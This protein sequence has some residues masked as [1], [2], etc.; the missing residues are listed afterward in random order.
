MPFLSLNLKIRR[1]SAA[2]TQNDPQES[3]PARCSATQEILAKVAQLHLNMKEDPDFQ[4]GV[5]DEI[6]KDRETRMSNASLRLHELRTQM[7]KRKAGGTRSLEV[8]FKP[9]AENVNRLERETTKSQQI[10]EERK[11]KNFLQFS[12]GIIRYHDTYHDAGGYGEVRMVWF[13]PNETGSDRPQYL[14]MKT[15]KPRDLDIIN[16]ERRFT[17]EADIWKL[18]NHENINPLFDV[19]KAQLSDNL[20]P[21]PAI[22]IL[23]PWAD[24]S[25]NGMG[26]ATA[27][28]QDSVNRDQT[29]TILSGILNGLQYMH[30]Q[31]DAVYHGDLKGNNVLLFGTP[32]NPV[33]KLTD[34]GL[35]K[36]CSP[37]PVQATK[38]GGNPLWTAPEIVRQKHQDV[39]NDG[40]PLPELSLTAEADLWGFGMTAFELITRSKVPM[41]DRGSD[42]DL[43]RLYIYGSNE[44]IDEE[45]ADYLDCLPTRLRP[46]L[47]FCLSADPSQRPTITAF[48]EEWDQALRGPNGLQSVSWDETLKTI[49]SSHAVYYPPIRRGDPDHLPFW[50]SWILPRRQARRV[51]YNPTQ[52]QAQ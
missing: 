28:L 40:P 29:L 16:T 26:T 12:K 51:K 44:Y 32:K 38:V 35:S 4:H 6:A 5:G 7:A 17:R 23:S 3:L 8:A 18:L 31:A 48:K 11:G 27:F 10:L 1:A 42:G 22:V 41:R 46:L 2:N 47:A 37:T 36:I 39:K 13:Q 9:L 49:P 30:L 45:T 50:R 52:S 20:N 24:V 19:F 25:V 21:Q 15:P 34:F 14:A 43:E 33:A